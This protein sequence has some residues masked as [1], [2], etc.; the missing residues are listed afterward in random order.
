[1]SIGFRNSFQNAQNSEYCDYQ[2][3]RI[4]A[5]GG[6]IHDDNVIDYPKNKVNENIYFNK[7]FIVK[8]AGPERIKHRCSYGY[9]ADS[10]AVVYENSD[11]YKNDKHNDKDFFCKL[12]ISAQHISYGTQK[13]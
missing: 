4:H 10:T 8:E 13:K 12:I 6:K 3:N 2:N 1:M 9:P 7:Q 5:A 11:K